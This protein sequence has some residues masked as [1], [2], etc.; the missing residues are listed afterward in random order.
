[1]IAM[2]ILSIGAVG[3]IGAF[4][5]I[6]RATQV[7]KNKTLASGLAQEKLQILGQLP[8]NQ[9]LVTPSPSYRTD[10][11]PNIP[12]DTTYFPP[13]TIL[14]GG[15]VYTRLTNVQVVT[16]NLGQLQILPPTNPDTGMR[17]VTSY[18]LWNEGGQKKFQA[19][20]TVMSN[21][22]TVT[23]NSN[24]IGTL[25][26]ASSMSP[27]IGG[28]V[29]IAENQGWMNTTNGS[30]QYAISAAPGNF[31][32]IAS[33]RGYFTQ[34]LPVTIAPNQTLTN[35]FS[36]V[37]MS[38][39]SVT[40]TAWLNSGLV[41]SQVVVS[42][43]QANVNN[44]QA[45]YIELYNPTPRP[46]AIQS[47]VP[48]T[49]PAIKLNFQS[50]PGCGDPST[51]ADPNW[52]IKLVYVSTVVPAYGYYVI[53]N[54]TTF[55][56]NGTSVAAD[57]Y[58]ES[59]ANTYC[60]TPPA[61]WNTAS[62]PPVMA[63]MSQQGHGGALWLKDSYGNV[64]DSVGWS[65]NGNSPP[66]CVPYCIP[67]LASGF[68]AAT[69]IVRTSSP[70]FATNAWG[71]AYDTGISS[72]DFVYPPIIT[73]F[74][75]QPYNSF[76]AITPPIAGRPPIGG[77]VTAS[78][79][80][81]L[82]STIT[83]VGYPPTGYFSLTNVATGTWTVLI[84]SGAYTLENDTV[85]IPALGSIYSFPSSTTFLNKPTSVGFIAG[86]VTDVFG[87]P[88]S[89]PVPITV[90][91]GPAGSNTLASTSNGRYI[92]TVSVSSGGTSGHGMSGGGFSPALVNVSAN[93][94]PSGNSSYITV[95]SAG[96]SVQVGQITDQVN[97]VLSQGGRIS[98]F[99]SRDG[100]NGIPG[101]TVSAINTASGA[102]ADT[103]V[104]D[105]SGH[106]ATMNIAT[107]TYQ[108]VPELDSLEY[109]TPVSPTLTVTPG[110]SVFSATFTVTGA[111]GTI[112]GSVKSGGQPIT[113]GVLIFVTTSTL[114]G[115]P[116]VP[117][118]LSTATLASSAVYLA[119]SHED[120]TYSVGVRQSTVPAYNVYAYYTTVNSAGAVTFQ[121]QKIAGVPVLAGSTVTAQNFAW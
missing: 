118:V 95:S 51:C 38:S 41:I 17:L 18:I 75:F 100:I 49:F 2:A 79:G 105:S 50:A 116:P 120:G 93:P 87:S 72:I 102:S 61:T 92:L 84:T 21:P 65:H 6:Q 27:I 85:T 104:T 106:F 34:F 63:I 114:A 44:F 15:V 7:A 109:A 111:L 26:N 60:T 53:A 9:V 58:Y 33:A 112:S 31:N 97:F 77:V 20:N 37:P 54:T 29:N 101:V 121:T 57:A 59:D 108:V 13:E 11:T 32:L 71:P 98:G 14:E 55:M 119:S 25:R 68:A 39:G 19:L 16:E 96:V 113:S 22:D 5:G 62:I 48:G 3:L 86:T 23:S 28:Q 99:V 67:F 30:G 64:I 46:I 47:G 70:N 117:P 52:G 115:S 110:Q 69:E 80:L 82:P 76:G 35:D 83:A 43:A 4:L 81:S 78:D 107:G 91:P 1:M 10:Y 90:S 74:P 88:I 103:E 42:T 73:G 8:Y 45:Q 36:M 66:Q 94:G 56:V 89:L 12:Y 40:G 24:F